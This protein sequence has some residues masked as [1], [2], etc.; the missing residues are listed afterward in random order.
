[1]HHSWGLGLDGGKIIA[2]KPGEKVVLDVRGVSRQHVYGEYNT[3]DKENQGRTRKTEAELNAAIEAE[4]HFTQAY[5][6]K[7]VGRKGVWKQSDRISKDKLKER[8]RGRKEFLETLDTDFLRRII[9]QGGVSYPVG[10]TK[11]ELLDIAMKVSDQHQPAPVAKAAA[12]A[13]P[14]KAVKQV[15][16][17]VAA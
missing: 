13:A 10:A 8:E 17:P 14:K 5:A 16:E 3:A 2:F 15:A 6:L 7:T 12:V 9:A 4:S 11:D 1:M